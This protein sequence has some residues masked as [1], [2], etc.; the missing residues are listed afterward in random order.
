MTLA[1]LDASAALAL[2]MPD[3]AAAAERVAAHLSH[4]TA[5]A[6]DLFVYEVANVLATAQRRGRLSASNARRIAGLID[7]LDVRLVRPAPVAE[8]SSLAF[9]LGL[10][11]YD[12]AYLELAEREGCSLITG[13]E[14]LADI[15]RAQGV[16]VLA[17]T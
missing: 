9:T 4:A 8:L 1:V 13:D 12:A 15:S 10:S 6:P 14:R 3:E 16:T 11:A 7:R 2:A 5:T 17:V